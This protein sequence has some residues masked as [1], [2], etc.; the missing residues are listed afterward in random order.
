MGAVRSRLLLLHKNL[1]IMIL[2]T[3]VPL[4]STIVPNLNSIILNGIEHLVIG[5]TQMELTFIIVIKYSI[6]D[7]KD[8]DM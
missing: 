7:N 1:L 5:S 2:A 8:N 3:H 6:A 4:V